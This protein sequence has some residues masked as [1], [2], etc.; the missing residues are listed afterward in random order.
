MY[1]FNSDFLVAYLQECTAFCSVGSG[2]IRLVTT[3]SCVATWDSTASKSFRTSTN[4]WHLVAARAAA[5]RRPLCRRVF[6]V[7]WAPLGALVLP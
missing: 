4:S 2:E 5:V 1:D 3:S 6:R 7:Q